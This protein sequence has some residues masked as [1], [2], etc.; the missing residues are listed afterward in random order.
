MGAYRTGRHSTIIGTLNFDAPYRISHLFLVVICFAIAAIVSGQ[1]TT[2]PEIPRPLSL[3]FT[4]GSKSLS[5]NL[6]FEPFDP[7]NDEPTHHFS[8][9]IWD[10]LPRELQPDTSPSG[11]HLE[12][13]LQMGTQGAEKILPESVLEVLEDFVPTSGR[14]RMTPYET[15]IAAWHERTF[16]GGYLGRYQGG[17]TLVTVD[18]IALY[19]LIVAA[20]ESYKLWR[21]PRGAS[22][23]R[24]STLTVVVREVNGAVPSHISVLPLT[25]GWIGDAVHANC[26]DRGRCV[27]GGMPSSSSTLFVRGQGGGVV[28]WDHTKPEISVLLKPTGLLQIDP[29]ENSGSCRLVV[30]V[31][32]ERTHAIVPIV[33]WINRKREDWVRVPENGLTINVPEGRYRIQ[34]SELDENSY[35]LAE[36]SADQITQ[37]AVEHCLGR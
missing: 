35:V 31:L 23:P 3:D 32:E 27:A 33:R 5:L 19:R 7:K 17:G 22:I 18:L 29:A 12:Y 26:D 15:S 16:E 6:T 14:Y 37:V 28:Y 8:L 36:V 4:P 2:S 34:T 9:G 1:E 30:R 10:R 20:W 21:L 11:G 13:S 25:E 24:E